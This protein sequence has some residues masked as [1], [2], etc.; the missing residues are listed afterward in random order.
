MAAEKKK[1]RHEKEEPSSETESEDQVDEVEQPRQDA[2][3]RQIKERYQSLISELWANEK[4][5]KDFEFP[6]DLR[7]LINK[8]VALW[9]EYFITN[10]TFRSDNANLF[11]YMETFAKTTKFL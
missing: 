4:Q 9:L 6:D 2:I 8:R 10:A 5:L 3:K 7:E 11:E 1:P